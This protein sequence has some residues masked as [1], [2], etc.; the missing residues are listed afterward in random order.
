MID[1]KNH[2]GS[3]RI[4]LHLFDLLGSALSAAAHRRPDWQRG[5]RP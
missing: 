4:F 1:L 3:V 2:D 5:L